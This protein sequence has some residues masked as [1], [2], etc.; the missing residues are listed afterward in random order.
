VESTVGLGF[1]VEVWPSLVVV[2]LPLWL[3]LRLACISR[4]TEDEQTVS[5]TIVPCKGGDLDLE[6][7]R[8]GWKEWY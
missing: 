4:G 2:G 8:D 5:G 6:N 1:I 3:T 7:I